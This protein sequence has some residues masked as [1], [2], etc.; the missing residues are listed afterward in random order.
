MLETI[1]KDGYLKIVTPPT[2][3][4]VNNSGVFKW[5]SKLKYHCKTK[6]IPIKYHKS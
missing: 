2:Y 1:E 4:F 3:I 6:Y 5:T